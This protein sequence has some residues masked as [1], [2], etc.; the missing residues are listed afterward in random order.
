MYIDTHTYVSIYD[1]REIDKS[2]DVVVLFSLFPMSLGV[3]LW[4]DE[5]PESPPSSLPT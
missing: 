2:G 3:S 1:E 5:V 4:K